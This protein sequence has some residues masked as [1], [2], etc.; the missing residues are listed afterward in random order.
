MEGSGVAHMLT[1][2]F[3]CAAI[4]VY[5]E[6]RNQPPDGQRQV[7]HVINNRMYHS[8]FPNDVCAVVKQ[9][10]QFSFYWDG[11]PER[12]RDKVAWEAAK[13]A[14]EEAYDA[15]YENLGAT[16]YHATYVQPY[17]SKSP[18]FVRLAKIG[19]HIFYEERER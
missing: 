11:K 9:R 3:L 7:V 19:D 13:T 16:H 2:A 10:H 4:A 17:W 14:V 5:Y 15:P 8:G 18:N 1:T 6:A 12:P